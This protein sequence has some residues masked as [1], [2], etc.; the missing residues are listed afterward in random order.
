MSIDQKIAGS[1][2]RQKG[3]TLIEILVSVL[4]FAIGLL[5]LASLHVVGQRSNHDAFLRSQAIIQAYDIADRMRVNRAGV[6]AGAYDD[7]APPATAADM[8]CLTSGC[9][10]AQLAAIDI[11]E[12]QTS[13]TS[14]LASGEG[15]VEAQTGGV[16]KITIFWDEDRDGTVTVNTDTTFITEVRP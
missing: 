5:G 8:S 6:E 7:I 2:R 4:I 15:I 10:P 11:Y 9:T 1:A 3:F 16:F 14:V 13:N 12:W